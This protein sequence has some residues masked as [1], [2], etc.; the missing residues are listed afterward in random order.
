MR[1]KHL[2]KHSLSSI[3]FGHCQG[4]PLAH[5]H[6]QGRKMWVLDHGPTLCGSLSTQ[7]T[8]DKASTAALCVSRGQEQ[9]VYMRNCSCTKGVSNGDTKQAQ[10]ISTRPCFMTAPTTVQ[11]VRRF[12]L[13]IRRTTGV[14][15]L[16]SMSRHLFLIP[17][18]LSFTFHVHHLW[19]GSRATRAQ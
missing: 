5:V 18:P 15:G 14:H 3:Q 6:V 9:L 16:G 17:A 1:G 10:T 4:A 11:G 13:V 12:G 19:G 8:I 2:L 7:A